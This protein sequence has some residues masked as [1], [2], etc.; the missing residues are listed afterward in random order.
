[1][2][3]MKMMSL[4]RKINVGVVGGG[5]ESDGRM[6]RII[7]E[8]ESC[9]AGG[10]RPSFSR[11]LRRAAVAAATSSSQIP[12]RQQIGLRLLGA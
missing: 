11:A 6:G 3:A 8:G 5:D 9:A 2:R 12:V 7:G 4:C 10:R 1:V